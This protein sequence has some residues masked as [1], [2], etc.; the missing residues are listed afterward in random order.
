MMMAKFD[1]N[2]IPEIIKCGPMTLGRCYPAD[3]INRDP[4]E[5]IKGY[6]GDVLIVHGTNMNVPTSQNKINAPIV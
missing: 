5:E 2:N 3:V 1:P 4:F 6:Q